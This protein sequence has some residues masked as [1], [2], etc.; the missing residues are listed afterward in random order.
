MVIKGNTP[1]FG[2]NITGYVKGEFGLGESSRAQI[3][4][5]KAADIPHTICNIE[6]NVH[7]S[8]DSTIKDDEF[9]TENPYAINL[10]NFN[11]EAMPEFLD[12]IGPDYLKGKYNIGYWAWELPTF[13]PEWEWLF[14]YYDEIWVPS[15]YCAEALSVVSPVP[16]VKIMHSIS[17]PAPSLNRAAINYPK[18]KFIFLFLFDFHSTLARKNPQGIVEAFKRAF[19]SSNQDVCLILKFSNGKHYPEQ[20]ELLKEAASSHPSI[21]FIEG[22]LKKEEVNA[23]FYN[24]NCYVSLHRAEGF[25]LT[26]AEAMYYGKPVIATGYSSN[27]EFMNVG[28]SFLV[29]YDLIKVTQDSGSYKKGNIW[30]EPDV[31]HTAALM[32]YVFHNYDSAQQIGIRAAREVKEKLSPLTIGKKIRHRLEHIMSSVALNMHDDTSN[33]LQ[34]K[35]WKQTAQELQEELEKSK[36]E[37]KQ[38]KA[39]IKLAPA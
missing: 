13:P 12:N 20:V 35:A 19:K 21:Q 17:L 6:S 30:A 32:H 33:Q 11:A 31:E 10:L 26:M 3:R 34:T 15:G 9:T 23:L 36:L 4:S 2:I 29:N 14:Q 7:R 22:H 25:G 8:L 27:V 38:L 39:R 18:N 16:V 37:I 28:N 24:S 5:I 1:L